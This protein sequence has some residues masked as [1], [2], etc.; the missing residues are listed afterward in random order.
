MKNIGIW[1]DIEKAHM[2]SIEND[3]E[4][5]TTILSEVETYH[6]KGGSRSKTLWG[7][8]DV[9]NEKRYLKRKNQQLKNYF[10]K[11]AELIKDADAI[12]L[13]GPAGTNEKLYKEL[14]NNY[15]DISVKVKGV[16]KADSMTNNQVKALVR[17][18]FNELKK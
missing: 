10:K 4:E 6:V 7:P 2:V 17:N 13:F 18:F 15:K 9:V 5:F 14:K 12:A 1:L 8:E 16:E 11:I 3:K